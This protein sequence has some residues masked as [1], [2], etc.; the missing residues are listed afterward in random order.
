MCIFFDLEGHGLFYQSISL[1]NHVFLFG[2]Q[3]G[4][5]FDKPYTGSNYDF[6]ATVRFLF[7]SF[8]PVRFQHSS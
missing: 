3:V 1:A 8:Q 5:N 4:Q 6:G 2:I 7:L